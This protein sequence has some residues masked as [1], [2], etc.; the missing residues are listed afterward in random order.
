[1]RTNV[2]NV[3]NGGLLVIDEPFITI[4]MDPTFTAWIITSN[5]Y[6][7]VREVIQ[8]VN[9]FTEETEL[10]ISVCIFTSW[11]HPFCTAPEFDLR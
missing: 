9:C 7:I 3:F 5:P 1:M 10:V 4:Q 2:F 6:L 11:A 8:E